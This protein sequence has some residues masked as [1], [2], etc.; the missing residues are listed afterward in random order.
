M[1]RFVVADDHYA[2]R[3]V[4]KARIII[5]C[6]FSVVGEAEN[7]EQAV[8]LCRE[9]RPDIAVLDVNM[10]PCNGDEAAEIITREGLVR[11]IIMVT[12]EKLALP[13][14]RKLGYGA[15]AKPFKDPTPLIREIKRV[16]GGLT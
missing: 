10:P 1:L 11:T 4:I 5:D 8:D 16:T 3:G 13:G 14:F 12:L 6:G 2:T 7:G 15:V 9:L